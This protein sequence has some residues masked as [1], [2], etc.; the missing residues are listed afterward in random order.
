MA[1][2]ESSHTLTKYLLLS[3]RAS[4]NN[5]I[6]HVTVE[7]YRVRVLT[8]MPKLILLAHL[9]SIS[10]Y[11]EGGYINNLIEHMTVEDYR[12][13]SFDK[14]AKIKFPYLRH[15]S[16]ISQFSHFKAKLLQCKVK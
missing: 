14:H 15:S 16:N 2:L 13:T 12:A 5:L 7:A 1:I 3:R 4:I 11:I 8:S 6:E 9:F 10:C